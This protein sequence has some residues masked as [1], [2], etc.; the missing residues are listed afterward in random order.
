MKKS[1][2]SSVAA[3]IVEALPMVEPWRRPARQEAEDAVRTLLAWAGDDPARPGLRQ[4]PA[5]VVDAYGEYFSGYKADAAAELT[6]TFE[7]PAGYG[8]MVLLKDIRFESHCE[9]HIAPFFGL[10]HVAYIPAGRIVGFSKLA[11]VVE[12]YARRLQTQEALTGEIASAIMHGLDAKGVAV[13]LSAEHQCVSMRGVRQHDVKAITM[14]L[15]GAFETED[16]WRSRFLALV[17]S[18]QVE[19]SRGD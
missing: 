7:D 13:M 8:D 4:T 12:I 14:R 9:H 2:I 6:A 18:P 11:R 19:K 1:P 17:Q 10:A 15:L 3:P 5:R 16:A